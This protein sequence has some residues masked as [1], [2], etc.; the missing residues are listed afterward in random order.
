MTEGVEGGSLPWLHEGVEG[1][2]A[3]RGGLKGESTHDCKLGVIT[4]QER[5]GGITPMI[6]G[7]G[8]IREDIEGGGSERS[9]QKLISILSLF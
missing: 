8:G 4:P 1:S 5:G 2:L 3:R 9:L 7:G 6:E